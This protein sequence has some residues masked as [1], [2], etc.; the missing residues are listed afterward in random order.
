MN[1]SSYEIWSQVKADGEERQVLDRVLSEYI[2]RE[3]L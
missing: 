3:E 1:D 2:R